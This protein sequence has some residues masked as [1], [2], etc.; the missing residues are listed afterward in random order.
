M[1]IISAPW[2]NK[3]W[4]MKFGRG[5]L[6]D[7]TKNITSGLFFSAVVLIQSGRTNPKSSKCTSLSEKF[8]FQKGHPYVFSYGHEDQPCQ[9]SF[10]TSSSIRVQQLEAWMFRNLLAPAR[11]VDW[12]SSW[13]CSEQ[14][15]WRA[16]PFRERATSCVEDWHSAF[17]LRRAPRGYF[18]EI[19]CCD[20]F[21][22]SP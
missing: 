2:F 1:E 10:S 4:K 9:I 22:I 7:H 18:D 17:S 6:H 14:T 11:S 21:Y 13:F 5:V 15:H 20:P 12:K 19:P 16:F 8:F 3:S